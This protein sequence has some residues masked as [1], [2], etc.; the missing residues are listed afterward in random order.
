MQKIVL[1][2]TRNHLESQLKGSN[3]YES[4]HIFYRMCE[5]WRLKTAVGVSGARFFTFYTEA[6]S[7]GKGLNTGLQAI[8]AI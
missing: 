8:S 3:I 2:L 7:C 6:I 5:T 1:K 4:Y